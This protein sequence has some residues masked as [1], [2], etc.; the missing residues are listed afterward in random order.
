MRLPSPDHIQVTVRSRSGHGTVTVRSRQ[1]TL[2]SQYDH[3][4][5]RYGHSMI[6][7]GHGTVTVRSRQVTVR[8]Q[9][10][11]VRSWYVTVRSHS[12][13]SLV[14]HYAVTIQGTESLQFVVAARVA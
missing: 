3:V 6:T 7:S 10:D 4:R 14:I 5:S 8:S 12:A 13:L 9:Y 2:R 1:V 11:H